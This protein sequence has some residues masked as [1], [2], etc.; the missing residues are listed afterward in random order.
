MRDLAACARV[1]DGSLI[2]FLVSTD[3]CLISTKSEAVRN[4]VINHLKQ[5][6]PIT[7]K[8]GATLQYLNYRI[9]QSSS[10]IAMDQTPCIL[11]ITNS[12][13]ANRKHTKTDTP[14]RTDR[15]VEDEIA[16]SQPCT[17]SDLDSFIKSFGEF[18]ST[19]GSILNCSV[20]SR[21]DVSHAMS[22]LGHFI[23]IPCHLGFYY[24]TKQCVISKLIQ[25]SL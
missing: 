15:K 9:T 16:N 5:Y 19:H 25:T 18:S 7:T 17:Q 6:F 21:L 22:R 8:E 2:L 10:F 12:Y 20:N 11:D 24:L 1:I 14:F 4:K 13:F 23:T 3:D